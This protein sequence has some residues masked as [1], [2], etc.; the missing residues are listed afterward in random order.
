MACILHNV[1]V[2]ASQLIISIYA[3]TYYV[4]I[5]YIIITVYAPK[6]IRLCSR[7]TYTHEVRFNHAMSIEHNITNPHAA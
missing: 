6:H 7:H 1:Y 5:Y 3:H 2:S 4:T